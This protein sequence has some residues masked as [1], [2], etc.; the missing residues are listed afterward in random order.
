MRTLKIDAEFQKLCPPLSESERAA[1]K[2]SIES[3]GCRD[4]I[5]V[6]DG[7][8]VDGH[9]RYDICREL[10]KPFETKSIEL[11]DRQAAE[12][13]I[14]SNQLARRNLTPLQSSY[15]RG[16]VYAATKQPAKRDGDSGQ[17]LK[18]GDTC[19]KLGKRF[20][21]SRLSIFNDYEV[22]KSIDK[23]TAG[24]RMF[25]LS[26]DN[27]C[28]KQHVM[29]LACLSAKNQEVIIAKISDGKLD[30]LSG[31]ILRLRPSSPPHNA[32]HQKRC[33]CGAMMSKGV[34]TCL[35]CD[36]T[37]KEVRKRLEAS[38]KREAAQVE[39]N[40][41]QAAASAK[42]EQEAEAS[43]WEDRLAE[44]QR[45]KKGGD[46][47]P[48]HVDWLLRWIDQNNDVVLSF[49]ELKKLRSLKAALDSVLMK[50]AG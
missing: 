48:F 46:G 26:P 4:A 23:L 30:H 22:A 16:L 1:L 13:W 20:G 43:D 35:K 38:E 9:N 49:A 47:L 45:V 10:G 27:V 11:A 32:G 33:K 19:S 8:I 5:V 31:A 3:E 37:D 2:E 29:D 44:L 21:V 41:S 15:L 7:T 25:V 12:Q 40:K 50:R 18:H 34:T 28:R 14:I 36:L 17:F 39:K 42:A 6:W 24:A